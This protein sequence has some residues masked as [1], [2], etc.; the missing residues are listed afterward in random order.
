MTFVIRLGAEQPVRT[1]SGYIAPPD[2]S[3]SNIRSFPFQLP[4]MAEDYKKLKHDWV[5]GLTGSSVADV[6]S[7]SLAMPVSEPLPFTFAVLY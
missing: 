6:N 4:A 5:T 2:T 7:V 3:H 1:K